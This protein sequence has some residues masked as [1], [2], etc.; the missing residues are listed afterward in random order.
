MVELIQDDSFSLPSF[1]YSANNKEER[2]RERGRE[3]R[4]KVVGKNKISR[5]EKKDLF[6]PLSLSLSLMTLI[7]ETIP[8]QSATTEGEE[9]GGGGGGLK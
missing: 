6:L 7:M 9:E 5:H 8:Q 2:E 3:R 1:Y 4:F